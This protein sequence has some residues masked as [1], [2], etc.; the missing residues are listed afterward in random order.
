M[1]PDQIKELVQTEARRIALEVYSQKGT[2]YGNPQVPVHIHNGIDSPIVSA[3]DIGGF[4]PL[5]ATPGGVVSP[6]Q[7]GNQ[8]VVQGNSSRSYGNFSTV[9]QAVFPIYPIPLIYG[10]GVGPDSAF[11]GGTAPLGTVLFF[12]NGLT[13]SGLWVKTPVGWYRFAPFSV[14]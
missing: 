3:A 6:G 11:D 14:M 2:Q 4:L 9:S 5:P 8:V 12:E 7:L 1:S 10:S 13:L